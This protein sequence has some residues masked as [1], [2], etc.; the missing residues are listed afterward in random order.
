MV[1]KWKIFFWS[2]ER[3]KKLWSHRCIFRESFLAISILDIYFCP[4]SKVTKNFPENFETTKND[5][6]QDY[7]IFEAKYGYLI[8]AYYALYIYIINLNPHHNISKLGEIVRILLGFLVYDV[9]TFF[10]IILSYQNIIR[11]SIKIFW[12]FLGRNR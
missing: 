9:V 6:S 8:N 7:W 4:I 12:G 1:T 2:W 10:R 5:E 11:C 3:K